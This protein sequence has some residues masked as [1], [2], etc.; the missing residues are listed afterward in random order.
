MNPKYCHC[1]LMIFAGQ[2]EKYKQMSVRVYLHIYVSW[3]LQGKY[4]M[5]LECLVPQ[6]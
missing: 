5:S 4:K 1:E 3:S 6:I 2:I